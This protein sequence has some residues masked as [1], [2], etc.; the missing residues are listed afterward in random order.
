MILNHPE[1]ERVILNR[2]VLTP[3]LVLWKINKKC[4]GGSGSV[5]LLRGMI[6]FEK[7]LVGWDT[8]MEVHILLKSMIDHLEEEEAVLSRQ[9]T[10]INKED[11]DLVESLHQLLLVSVPSLVCRRLLAKFNCWSRLAEMWHSVYPKRI[12]NRQHHFVLASLNAHRSRLLLVSLTMHAE[13]ILPELLDSAAVQTLV[14]LAVQT[15]IDRQALSI[16]R[17]MVYSST[18]TESDTFAD[19]TG[20]KSKSSS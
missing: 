7:L 3:L 6:A 1:A 13:P 18:A 2:V 8:V 17:N 12:I 4:V 19:A 10:L 14:D 15:L 9:S 5:Q 16:F 11:W 20:D